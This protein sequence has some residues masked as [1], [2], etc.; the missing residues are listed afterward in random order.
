MLQLAPA[1]LFEHYLGISRLLAGQLDFRSAIRSVANEVAYIIPHDHL[2][3]CVLVEDGNYHTAYET[4][5]GP[6]QADLADASSLDGA[7]LYNGACATCHGIDG[8]GTPDR[9]YPSLTASSTVGASN[10]ANLVLT[11]VEGI[12]REGADGH[13][14]MQTFG[15]TL[16]NA[17]I[18]AIASYVTAHFGNPDVTVDGAAVAE[19]RAG[20]P[21][22][23]IV[24]AAPWLVAIAGGLVVLILVGI[25][26]LI[27]FRRRRDPYYA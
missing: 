24:T 25:G 8:A 15:S 14:F 17:Q 1:T 23:L 7:V 12:D 4:G 3:V 27:L 13:A 21:T 11:I 18:A 20:G 19:L 9:T 22:P 16:S 5:N 2:D 6:T 10:P 26:S